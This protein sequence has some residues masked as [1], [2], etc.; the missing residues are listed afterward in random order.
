MLH[1]KYYKIMKQPV[2]PIFDKTKLQK[3]LGRALYVRSLALDCH[4]VGEKQIW[5]FRATSPAIGPPPLAAGASAGGALPRYGQI[6]HPAWRIR[7]HL[8]RTASKCVG[9]QSR[10]MNSLPSKAPSIWTPWDCWPTGPSTPVFLTASDGRAC[11]AMDQVTCDA[12]GQV[13]GLDLCNMG[14]LGFISPR[15]GHLMHLSVG[16]GLIS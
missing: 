7:W 10:R 14:L 16:A 15:I 9:Q 1:N 4:S 11:D 8:P 6:C 2:I 5:G 13:I 12:M 3:Q